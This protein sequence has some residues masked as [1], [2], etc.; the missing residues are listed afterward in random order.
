MSGLARTLQILFLVVGFGFLIAALNA[1]DSY[2]SKNLDLSIQW[3]C[4]PAGTQTECDSYTGKIDGQTQA[5]MTYGM[6]G[7]GF[8][9]ASA[10]VAAG[11]NR[12]APAPVP[13]AWP[14]VPVAQPWPAQVAPPQYAPPQQQPG[15]PPNAG[16]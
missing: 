10:S 12:R 5:P 8:L 4:K 6:I 9:L 2:T 13:A 14:A 16:P 7:L 1:T 15:W 3:M 11:A